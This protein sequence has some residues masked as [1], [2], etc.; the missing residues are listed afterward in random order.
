MVATEILIRDFEPGDEAAFRRLNE[1]WIVRLFSL[2]A[3]DEEVLAD[4]QKKILDAGG[5]IFFAVREGEAVGCCAL[6][7]IGPGEFE[8]AKMG[9]TE[10]SK[11]GG[12][13]RKLLQHAI[14]EAREAGAT[15]LYL[16]TNSK[17]AP[18][19]SL[20][21]QLG[22]KHLPPVDSP[23]ARANVFMELVFSHA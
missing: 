23:Y 8:V 21:K 7:V 4:P 9:V 2:E 17:L 11:R 12:V 6:I 20:Y 1:E 5:R 14:D 18:A 15:R 10:S 19:I 16:E 3:K 22:F 13:G